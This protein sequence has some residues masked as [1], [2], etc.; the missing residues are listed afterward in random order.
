MWLLRL[1]QHTKGC[2]V[3]NFIAIDF[4]TANNV[5]RSACQIGIVV[6]EN[7]KITD[8][9]V[10]LIKPNPF[11]FNSFFTDEVHGIDAAM[12]K[13]A[14]T[15]DKLWTEIEKYFIA[16]PTILAHNA[17]FD[18]KVLTDLVDYYSIDYTVP[19]FVC[20]VWGARKL[21]PKLANHQ[22][23]TVCN[24]IGY[25]LNHHEALSDARG[26]AMIGLRM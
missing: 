21:F 15:F 25:N 11:Y 20:T 12:V 14:P 3:E 26:A 19:P 24:H 23:S 22:L 7:S 8:E 16:A 13:D 2:I 10:S 18:R 1:F 4:E 17:P 5:R 9:F 6:V